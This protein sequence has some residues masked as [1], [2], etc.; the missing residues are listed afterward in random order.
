MFLFIFLIRELLHNTF[1]LVDF[2][3]IYL[4]TY[5]AHYISEG[6]NSSKF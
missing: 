6:F 1:L 5:S 4:F 3:F 2:Y